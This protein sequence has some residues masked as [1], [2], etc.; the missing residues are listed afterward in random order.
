M[1]QIKYYYKDLDGNPC[2]E[3][4]NKKT[5]LTIRMYY[6]YVFKKQM[7]KDAWAPF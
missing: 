5:K 3:V 2:C 7:K 4:M 6:W 1:I